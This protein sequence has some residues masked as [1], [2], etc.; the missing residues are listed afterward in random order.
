[1]EA[2]VAR[3]VYDKMKATGGIWLDISR[4]GYSLKAILSCKQ[5]WCHIQGYLLQLEWLLVLVVE[6][7]I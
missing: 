4:V 2:V 5:K 3:N 7:S 1:M 6:L